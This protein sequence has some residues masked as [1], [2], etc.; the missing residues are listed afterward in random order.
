MQGT[1]QHKKSEKNVVR[2]STGGKSDSFKFIDPKSME[3]WIS[4]REHA[5]QLAVPPQSKKFESASQSK[6]NGK[7]KVEEL[8]E[9]LVVTRPCIESIERA[10]TPSASSTLFRT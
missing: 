6:C 3:K 9:A 4:I 5:I 7:R 2:G 10:L 1:G 8:E